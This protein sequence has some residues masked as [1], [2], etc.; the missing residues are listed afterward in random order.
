MVSCRPTIL[1]P[2]D[3]NPKRTS[4]K[5]SQSEEV[6]NWQTETLASHQNLLKRIYQRTR[7]LEEQQEDALTKIMTKIEETKGELLC[8]A[9]VLLLLLLLLV[10]QLVRLCCLAAVDQQEKLPPKAVGAGSLLDSG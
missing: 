10:W 3:K 9:R 4:L 1:D 2:I 6:L 8:D 5:L 7:V